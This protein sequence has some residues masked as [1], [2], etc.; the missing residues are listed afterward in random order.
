MC[1][2]NGTTTRGSHTHR[3]LDQTE[4]A[5]GHQSRKHGMVG[6]PG[7][8]LP[9][10]T[11]ALYSIAVFVADI[12]RAKRFYR[13]VLGLPLVREGSFGAEFLETEPHLAVHPAVHPEARSLVGRHT[14]LTF[15]VHGILHYCEHLHEQGVRFIA[16]PTRQAFG[17]MAMIADPDGNVYAIWDDRV[18]DEQPADSATPATGA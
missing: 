12:D 17:I 5:P 8:S 13:D 10:M 15:H 6:L 18:P 16:E 9:A 7:L 11:P 3:A 2:A 4:F 1:A 14:G